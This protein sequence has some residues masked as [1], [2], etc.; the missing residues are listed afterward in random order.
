MSQYTTGEIARLCSVSVR[1]VQYYDSRGI[2]IPSALSEGGRRLY[3]EADVKRLRIICFLRDAGIS[4]G[5]IARLF[6]ETEAGS[7]IVTLIDEQEKALRCEI[8]EREKQMEL[9]SQIRQGLKNTS[10][11]SVESIGDIAYR[12]RNKKQMRKLHAIMLIAG[13]PLAFAQWGSV[14][15]GLCMGIWWPVAL[16]A[17]LATLFGVWVSRFYYRNVVYICPICHEVFRPG[18]WE[19]FWARHTPTLRRLTCPRCGNKGF[20]VETY[21][22]EENTNG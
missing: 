16:Y 5:G 15:L 8:S 3:G 14:I 2:L 9:L 4:I 19:M 10:H 17:G 18:F 20:C 11:F 13:I 21:G 7:V 6:E 22:K 12:M 1:T